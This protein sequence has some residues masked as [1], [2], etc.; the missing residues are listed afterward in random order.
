LNIFC[1]GGVFFIDRCLLMGASIQGAEIMSN[2][3]SYFLISL[4]LNLSKILGTKQKHIKPET[5]NTVW[6]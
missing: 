4:V 1:N 3:A 2:C 5:I 6:I